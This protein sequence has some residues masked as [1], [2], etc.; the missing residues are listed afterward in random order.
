[1]KWVDLMC[2]WL[3]EVFNIPEDYEVGIMISIGYQDTY[4]VLPER[5]KDK[6]FTPRVR[7]P[8][9]E[10]VYVEEFGVDDIFGLPSL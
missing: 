6:A 10:I 5:L 9:S 2:R 4:H 3:R 8:L 1:M 7:K